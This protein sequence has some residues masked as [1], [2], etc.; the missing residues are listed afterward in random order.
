MDLNLHSEMRLKRS[1]PAANTKSRPKKGPATLSSKETEDERGQKRTIS[2]EERKRQQRV[3]D[4]FRHA[5]SEVL[6]SPSFTDTLQ[7]VKQALYDRDFARAFGNPEYLEVYA[8][9]WSPTRALCYAS[10]LERIRDHLQS[11]SCPAPN[12]TVQNQEVH[13]DG[14]GEGEPLAHDLLTPRQ[15]N[16]FSIGGG[17]AELVALG[18]FLS[19]QPSSSSS[20]SSP[21]LSGAITLLDSGP[22]E[23]VVT[24]LTE[25]L[26]TPPPISKYASEAARLANAAMVPPSRFAA[27]VLRQDVLALDRSSLPAVLGAAP[28]LVT[29]LFTLNELFTAGGLRRTTTLLLNLTAAVPV[30]SLLLVVDSPGSYSEAAVGKE[31]KRYP[32]HW[33]L[34]RVLLATRDEPVGGRRWA[35]LESH[36]SLWFRLAGEQGGGLDYPIALENMR[37]QM[38]LY[39]AEDANQDE[40][41]EEEEEEERDGDKNDD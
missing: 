14:D 6:S 17:A 34:D 37:Y 27:S 20:S 31:A 25:A 36:E 11:L 26:T 29:L 33:L 40:D 41:E 16:I 12:N 28:L 32:M 21:P 2:P 24:K 3:L 1:T 7:S 9:R 39:R 30:G 8:A 15:L 13:Q 10:V 4:V 38:H 5:F 19:H 23:A 22:W 18:A 35:K